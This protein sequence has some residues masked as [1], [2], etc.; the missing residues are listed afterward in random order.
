MRQSDKKAFAKLFGEY[1]RVENIL[2]NYDEL[3]TLVALH[4][5]LHLLRQRRIHRPDG[6]HRI[7]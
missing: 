6:L 1:L 3:P 5:L 2:Q 4:C 7:A